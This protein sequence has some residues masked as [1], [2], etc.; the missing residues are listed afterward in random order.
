[1]W[2]SN[3]NTSE[4]RSEK[5]LKVLKCGASEGLERSVGPVV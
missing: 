5:T 3:F 2:C 4:N 1:M